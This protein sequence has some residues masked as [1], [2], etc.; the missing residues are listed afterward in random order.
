[1]PDTASALANDQDAPHLSQL[2]RVVNTFIEP[3]RTFN[4][5]KRNRSWWLPFLILVVLGYGFCFA[6]VQHV[7]WES[8]TTNVLRS[9]PKNAERLDK[10]TPAE[11][12]QMLAVT[13]G[14]M[15]G[16]MAGSPAVVLILNALLALL[17]W[18]G[19]AFVLGGTT[20]YGEMFAVAIFAALPNALNS[21]ISIVTA[22]VSD[23]QTYNLNVPSPAALAYF[24]APDSAPWLLSLA[25][26]LDVFSLWSLALA[27][28]GGAIVSRVKPLRGIV[29]VFGIW[30]LY[31]IVKV[32][33]AAAFS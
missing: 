5:I 15:E 4:D 2:E 33:I 23:P 20:T 24:L 10:S 31:V 19:F 1:M 32:G 7:G 14:I 13:K 3:S 9:Q 16:F 6:A 8:L 28:F 21:L 29:L 27:G 17:L 26:S 11:Q 18:G 25:K 22:F 30:L 12:A